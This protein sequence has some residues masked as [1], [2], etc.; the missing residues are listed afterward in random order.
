MFE[1]LGFPQGG[2]V[3]LAFLDG[4]SQCHHILVFF[5]LP[6]HPSLLCLFLELAFTDSLR[7]WADN[8]GM[9]FQTPSI[10]PPLAGLQRASLF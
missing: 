3:G 5:F 8:F 1:L 9:L 6:I 10:Y 7:S 4:G 2:V